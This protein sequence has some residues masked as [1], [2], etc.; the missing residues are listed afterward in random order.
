M[1]RTVVTLKLDFSNALYMVQPLTQIQKLQLAQNAVDL[2]LL[3]LSLR[4]HTQPTLKVF[5]WLLITYWFCFNVL[6][7]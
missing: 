5:L 7:L 3:S 4:E 1:I 6:V 2:L